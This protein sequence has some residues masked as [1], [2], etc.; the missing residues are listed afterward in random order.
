VIVNFTYYLHDSQETEGRVEQI[1][2]TATPG[3]TIGDELVEK[4]GRPFYEVEL[5]CTLDT[6]TGAVQIIS[7]RATQ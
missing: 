2:S 4:I 5:G 6:D 3:I 1:E 7:A